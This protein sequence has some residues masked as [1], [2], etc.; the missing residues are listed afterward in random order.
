MPA[1]VVA[2]Q[3]LWRPGALTEWLAW[4]I[5]EGMDSS[6]RR[7]HCMDMCTKAVRGTGP[8]R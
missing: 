6:L 1:D 4:R 3:R 2:G 8:M 7:G 5:L